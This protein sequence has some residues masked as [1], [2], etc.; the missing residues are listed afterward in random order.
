VFRAP[1][2]FDPTR[3][4]SARSGGSMP[5]V[6]VRLGPVWLTRVAPVTALVAASVA[7]SVAADKGGEVGARALASGQQSPARRRGPTPSRVRAAAQS[8]PSAVV[9]QPAAAGR[10]DASALSSAKAQSPLLRRS[11]SAGAR[12]SAGAR[13]DRQEFAGWRFYHRLAR[14]RC[15]G[16][17]WSHRA[18]AR[19]KPGASQRKP[20]VNVL[21]RAHPITRL[22]HPEPASLHA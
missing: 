17:R 2:W 16:R 20:A 18:E 9:E 21:S 12:A 7:A 15:H 6:L 3:R 14:S 13:S 10:A 19:Q 8:K 4:V 11:S 1:V 5:T 22:A